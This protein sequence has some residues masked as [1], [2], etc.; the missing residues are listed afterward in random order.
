MDFARAERE[1][2]RLEEMRST[3]HISEDEYRG[4][5]SALRVTDQDGQ[6]WMLQER[7]G[8]WYV[9]YGNQWIPATPDGRQAAAMPPD[10]RGAA[11]PAAA[12]E[13][14]GG[15]GGKI[16]RWIGVWAAIWVAIA[17]AVMVLAD[18]PQALIGVGAAAVLSLIL[19]LANLNSQWSGQVT[20][21]RTVRERVN[22]EDGWHH[23]DVT[24][25]YVRLD[26]GKVKKMQPM[27]GWQVGD[28]LVKAKGDSSIRKL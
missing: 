21:I 7:T 22:D 12:P 4:R 19:M 27:P 20:D 15:G 10:T 3:G 13:E 23:R 24:Y 16:A 28:R 18:E 1:F 8:Q 26:N 2:R 9:Y 5:L 11:G 6:L 17:V 25:A 14:R